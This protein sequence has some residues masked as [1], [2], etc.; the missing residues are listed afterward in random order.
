M[1]KISHKLG[2]SWLNV[3]RV[4]LYIILGMFG[5]SDQQERSSHSSCSLGLRITL[6]EVT[7]DSW[8]WTSFFNGFPSTFTCSKLGRY[9]RASTS[10]SAMKFL[11][12]ST[13]SKEGMSRRTGG[14]WMKELPEMFS[15]SNDVQALS[16]VGNFEIR[17]LDTF[18]SGWEL[19]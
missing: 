12:A 14:S 1:Y 3:V 17:L 4:S 19:N 6:M 13:V 5:L 7:L 8:S 11:P 15:L 9:W 18:R 2:A 16:S 10:T